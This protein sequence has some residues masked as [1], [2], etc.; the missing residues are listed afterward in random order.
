MRADLN[1]LLCE[2]ERHGSSSSFRAVRRSQRFD[3]DEQFTARRESMKRRYG[4]DERKSFSENLN[5]LYGAVRKAVGTPWNTFYSE[6]CK[7]FDKR[8]VINQHILDHLFRYVEIKDV[9][10]D[11]KGKLRV[12]SLYRRGEDQTIEEAGIEYYVDPRDGIL[13][14]NN[15]FMSY[16]R[17]WRAKEAE[18]A[19]E[20]A[21][22]FIKLD[23]NNVL[24]LVDSVWY[25]FELK[26]APEGKFT[27]WKPNDWVPVDINPNWM[28]KFDYIRPRMANWDEL[29]DDQ[30]ARFGKRHFEGHFV[31]DVYYRKSVAF[32][33]T[34]HG[35][36][37][38]DSR[39]DLVHKISYPINKWVDPGGRKYHASKK[40][41][42]KKQLKAAGI[43]Q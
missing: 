15:S 43:I 13:K 21:K 16:S 11:A 12:Q 28:K 27:F 4:Y 30:K 37:L 42:S 10:V 1:K 23:E 35:L 5:P 14:R 2:H 26:D 6:L 38:T 41:A 24:R 7:T 31:Y 22:T 17:R 25:H 33:P 19:A 20:V 9:Y 36:R 32:T 29:N 8:S 40:Q 34:R 18:V 3:L 39:G